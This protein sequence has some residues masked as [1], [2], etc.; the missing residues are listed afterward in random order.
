MMYKEGRQL[1][2]RLDDGG[3]RSRTRAYDGHKL[4]R[5]Y[6]CVRQHF[7]AKSVSKGKSPARAS[8]EDQT[9]TEIPSPIGN[10]QITKWITNDDEV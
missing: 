4:T 10:C 9:D 2:G 8:K 6:A 3:E 1:N 7:G 5:L